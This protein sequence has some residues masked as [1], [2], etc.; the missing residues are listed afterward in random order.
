MVFIDPYYLTIILVLVIVMIIGNLY[1]LAHYTH[2]ADS[3][4]GS[5]T[6]TKGLLVSNKM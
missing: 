4:F 3:F 2:Y 1:F 5:S 6:A